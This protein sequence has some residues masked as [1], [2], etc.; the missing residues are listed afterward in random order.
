MLPVL[1][2][3]QYDL[4]SLWQILVEKALSSVRSDGTKTVY[5]SVYTLWRK[6]CDDHAIPF[7]DLT[8]HEEKGSHGLH[9]FLCQVTANS[10][11][12]VRFAALKLIVKVLCVLTQSSDAQRMLSLL[13]L[14]KVPLG[15]EDDFHPTILTLSQFEQILTLMPIETIRDKRNQ[16]IVALYMAT[17]ARRSEIGLNTFR[18]IATGLKWRDFNEEM[19]SVKLASKGKRGKK[20]PVSILLHHSVSILEAWRANYT[21]NEW[22][23]PVIKGTKN[24][25]VHN[26][27]IGDETAYRVIQDAGSL[28]GIHLR[29]HDIRRSFI[30]ASLSEVGMPIEEVQKQVRHA[31]TSQTGG[32]FYSQGAQVRTRQWIERFRSKS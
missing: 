18:G 13:T 8:P 16:A 32:Y 4:E 12:Q 15:D 27:P 26:T 21:F 25:L 17:G 7:L 30:T 6:Y 9:H 28:I 31:K 2:T 1:Q 5:L 24:M 14:Y 29:P 3:N 11:R 19:Q 20:E 23:F 22:V 10:T